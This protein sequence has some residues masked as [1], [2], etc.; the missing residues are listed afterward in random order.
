MRPAPTT[1]FDASFYIY[2]N[3]LENI[4]QKCDLDIESLANLPVTN[5]K[6]IIITR[7]LKWVNMRMCKYDL[8]VE[9]MINALENS[10][11]YLYLKS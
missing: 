7:L 8:K 9:I 5:A 4:W 11:L 3:F 1:S 10:Y 2:T 6:I